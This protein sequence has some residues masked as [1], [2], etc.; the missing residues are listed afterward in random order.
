MSGCELKVA[1]GVV[2]RSPG[3]VLLSAKAV[4]APMVS[5]RL[6]LVVLGR[7]PQV[8][9]GQSMFLVEASVHVLVLA[10]FLVGG[11]IRRFS[12]GCR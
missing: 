9:V 4:M 12:F 8:G 2:L 6:L 7:T 3:G 10:L 5:A 1:I 11:R